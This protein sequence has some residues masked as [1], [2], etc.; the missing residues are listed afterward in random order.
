MFHLDTLDLYTARARATFVHA[1]AHELR[2][3]PEVVRRD[4]GRLLVACE[5]HLE[6]IATASRPEPVR[7]E[8]SAA[9]EAA[10]LELLRDPQPAE[11]IVADVE[12]V[13]IVG[14]A[15]NALVAY[16]AAVSHKLDSPLA[17]LVQ[18]TSAAGKSSL[19][20]AVL[21]LIPPERAG[22]ARDWSTRWS[23]RC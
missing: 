10:A 2:I 8:L 12:R 7:V 16:L 18:S 13:G 1:A 6:E 5:G 17:V 19:V 23:P 15:T 22:W 9:E 21:G 11:R 20:E 4:L 3:G 14:E